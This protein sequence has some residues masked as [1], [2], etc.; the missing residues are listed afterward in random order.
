LV[1]FAHGSGSSRFSPRNLDAAGYLERRGFATLLFDLL[2]EAEARDRRNVFDIPLLGARVVEA[3][4]WARAD[5]RTFMLPIGLF[6][7]ST[8]AGAAIVAAAARADDVAAIVSRGGRPDLA[9][10][11]LGLVRAP[12]ILIVGGNDRDVLQLNQSAQA[13]MKCETFLAIIPGAS[14]LFEETGTLE[15]ALEAAGDWFARHLASGRLLFDDRGAAGRALAAEVAGRALSGPV[16]Y[17]LP[18]GGVP[19]AIEIARRLNAPL[20]LLLVRKIGVPWQ[21]ELAAGAVIDGEQPDLVLN[22]DIVRAARLTEAEILS[23]AR[24]QLQEIER[25]RA[26]YMPGRT[27]VSARGRTAVLVDDGVAT[28]ASMEAAIKAIRRRAPL[29]VV[30]AVPVASRDAA[31]MLGKFVDEVIC[32]GTPED[33]GGVGGFYRDFHQLSDDEVVDLLAEHAASA[34]VSPGDA[35]DGAGEK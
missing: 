19:V 16:V 14:H 32:L 26:H 21:P 30:V 23:L 3:I 29:R 18:R 8:G 25:R 11:A 12:T 4:D 28:G 7:A 31:T 17:A 27:P 22:D 34:A 5:A 1:I 35:R 6:G 9:D 24:E 33:F 15:Q 2:T 10:R 13:R 20:D